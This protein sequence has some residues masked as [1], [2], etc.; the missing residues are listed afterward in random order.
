MYH[1]RSSLRTPGS[2]V[3]ALGDSSHMQVLE[4][5]A[6]PYLAPAF[7]VTSSI[8][9]ILKEIN[10]FVYLLF[11]SQERECRVQYA[12]LIMSSFEEPA[13]NTKDDSAGEILHFQDTLRAREKIHFD[14]IGH[15][16]TSVYSSSHCGCPCVW[17]VL[18]LQSETR[19]A[20][21]N[22]GRSID[23]YLA[24]LSRA[25]VVEKAHT[26]LLRLEGTKYA[27]GR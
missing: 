27:G 3:F 24:S 22:S 11:A 25:D 14:L 21:H 26:I 19:R 2:V 6:G 13:T 15:Q 18:A 9:S 23:T 20:Q 12:V 4:L 1:I 10:I 16:Q 17:N 8:F 7:C 5:L